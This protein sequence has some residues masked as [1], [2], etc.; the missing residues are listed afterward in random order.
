MYKIVMVVIYF[1]FLIGVGLYFSKRAQTN[2]DNFILAGRSAPLWV[3][4]GSV[5]AT[6]VN[7]ASLMGYAGT[8]FGVG[9]AGYWPVAGFLFTCIWMG[10]FVIPKLREAEVSTIPE[11]FGKFYGKQ[12][13]LTATVLVM[14]RDLAVTAGVI[15]GMATIFQSLF[16]QLSLDAAIVITIGVTLLVTITGGSWSVLYTDAIQSVFII[17][18]TVVLLPIA[19]SK[20]GGWEAFTIAIPETHTMVMNAGPRQTIG[21]VLNGIFVTLAYQTIVQRGLSASSTDHAKK[22]LVYGGVVCSFWYV[23]PF[24]LGIAALVL[25]PGSRADQAYLNITGLLGPIPQAFFAIV[26]LSACVT[27]IDSCILTISSNIT[28]DIY[29]PFINPN[30]DDK[31]LVRVS[32]IGTLVIIVLASL[33]ARAFPY[34]LELLWLGGRIMAS[35]LSPVWMAIIFWPRSRHAPKSTLAAMITGAVVTVTTQILQNQ[36]VAAAAGAGATTFIYSWDP[37]IIGLPVT[38]AILIIG[39]LIETKNIKTSLEENVAS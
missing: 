24:V 39:T 37:V 10:F 36:A 32:Q 9:I 12:H 38:F 26:L 22:A 17:V 33:I 1:G 8:G 15:I 16:P 25:F 2:A 18:G 13:R 28:L 19:V 14:C 30:A 29:K 4:V 20:M 27:T 6:W 21:W 35:G 11:V 7:S 31:I 5:F 23:I 3:V 34:I